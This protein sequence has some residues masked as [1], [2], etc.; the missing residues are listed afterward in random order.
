MKYAFDSLARIDASIK[1]VS[2]LRLPDVPPASTKTVAALGATEKPPLPPG[3]EPLAELRRRLF[4]HYRGSLSAPPSRRDIRY[5]PWVLWNGEPRAANLPELLDLI[6]EK[7]GSSRRLTS[8][9]VEAWIRDFQDGDEAISEAGRRI[10][11]LLAKSGGQ[12]L[13]PWLA[14]HRE[15]SFFDAAKGPNKLAIELLL[16]SRPPMQILERARLHNSE[17]ASS[18]YLRAVLEKL[19]AKLPSSLRRSKAEEPLDRAIEVLVTSEGQLRFGDALRGAISR[20][21][22]APWLDGK[23]EPSLEARNIVQTFLLKH[24]GDPRIQ[25]PRWTPVGKEGTELVRRW[26]ARAS[27]RAFFALVGN[28]ALDKHWRYREAFWTACLDRNVIEDAW[29]VFAKGVLHDARSQRELGGA[30]GRLDDVSGDQSVLLMRVG[31]L[32][33]C[34]WSHNGKLRAWLTEPDKTPKLY[35]ERYKKFELTKD[36]LLFP[37][38]P[39]FGSRGTNNGGGLSHFGSDT[40]YWQG[41]V[42]EMLRRHANL[43]LTEADWA[44]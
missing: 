20:G 7:A 11:S 15:F 25:G 13:N 5:A 38:N 34:E 44:P 37:P 31:P 40:S 16:D 18:G 26:L 9:L 27:L 3:P 8:A 22:L 4:K 30:Y 6:F 24:L 14:L 39:D 2:R 41:S 28:H 10:A 35:K 33:F 23:G 43:K 32:T 21:L 19:L 42:A 29:V 17:H 1:L 12:N 36:G